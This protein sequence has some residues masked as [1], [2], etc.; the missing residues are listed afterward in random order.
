MLRDTAILPA[1]LSANIA[2]QELWQ[3]CFAILFWLQGVLDTVGH[4]AGLVLAVSSPG[5]GGS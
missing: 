2:V 1:V 5:F 3:K 4:S